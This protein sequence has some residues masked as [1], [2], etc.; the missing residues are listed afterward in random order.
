MAHFILVHGAWHGGWCF[1]T[2]RAELTARG[3]SSEAPDLV[4]MG[5]DDATLAAV[6]LAD[7]AD[8]V[9]ALVRAA[10][11]PV[12]LCGHSRGGLVVSAV[13]E[14][15]PD[16]IAASVYICAMM[17]PNGLSRAQFRQIFQPNAAFEA[18]I[19]PTPG[20]AGTIINAGRPNAADAAAVFAHLTPPDQA[21]RAMARLVAEPNGPRTTP[22]VLS[23]DRY[24][25]VPRHYIACLQDRTI[26][27]AAQRAMIALQP[28]THV[29]T[30]DTDH[31]PHLSQPA[32]LADILS[33][34]ATVPDTQVMAS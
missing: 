20:G 12:F 29:V 30:L 13:A 34:I 19:S 17:F 1:D 32:R 33:A 2:L 10:P 9:E 24:G 4:G 21:A 23:P 31:S 6:T 26:P 3:Q 14:R 16:P 5:G 7:W 22:L 18:L 28:G 11:E 15:L 25:R 27:I 8:Q